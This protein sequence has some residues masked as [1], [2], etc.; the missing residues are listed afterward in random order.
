MEMVILVVVVDLVVA[1]HVTE[2]VDLLFSVKD[3]QVD[4]DMSQTT[5]RAVAAVVLV[6]EVWIPTQAGRVDYNTTMAKVAMVLQM[7]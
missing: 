7:T 1:E 3:I 6:K 5:S 2:L 4:K